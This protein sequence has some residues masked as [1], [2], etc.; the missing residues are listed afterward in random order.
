MR[1]YEMALWIIRSSSGSW[2]LG[3]KHSSKP[4]S[5][6]LKMS[7]TAASPRSGHKNTSSLNLKISCFVW[8][9]SGDQTISLVSPGTTTCI[10]S[11]MLLARSANHSEVHCRCKQILCQG[12]VSTITK[13]KPN[14]QVLLNWSGDGYTVPF[15]ICKQVL[16]NATREAGTDEDTLTRVVVMHAEKDLKGICGAFQK[17]TSVTLEQV[18]AKETSGDYRSFLMALLGS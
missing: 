7:T 1:L 11:D 18:I 13:R 8:N 9:R 6:A 14:K 2:V 4:H 5:A 12:E 10:R 17:R 16:R 3:A 15:A